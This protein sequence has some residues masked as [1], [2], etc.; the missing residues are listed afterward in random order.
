M[1][2]RGYCNFTEERNNDLIRAY[3]DI[4]CSK[5]SATTVLHK[6][7]MEMVVNSPSSHFWV[8]PERL[9]KIILRINKGDSLLEMREIQREMF[10]ELYRLYTEHIKRHPE[11]KKILS[12]CYDLVS[13]PAPKFYLSVSS[14]LK[15]YKR[16][17]IENR[18]KEK[19]HRF[20]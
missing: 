10:F 7:I 2:V 16:Q 4:M 20:I 8:S 9:Y 6:D 5:L 11:D 1:S 15:L 3:R 13:C 19:H 18:K 12:I 14:A 17:I